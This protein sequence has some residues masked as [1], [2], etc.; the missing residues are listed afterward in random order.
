MRGLKAAAL[1]DRHVYEHRVAAH[2]AQLLARD[3]VWGAS[4][5]HEHGADHEVGDRQHLFDRERR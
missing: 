4:A 5:V 2:Q 1:V 3:D